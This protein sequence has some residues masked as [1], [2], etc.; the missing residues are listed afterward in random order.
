LTKIDVDTGQTT[1]WHEPGTYPSEPIFVPRPGCQAEDDGV[2]LSVV[3]DSRT[4]RLFLLVLDAS[5][6]TEVART[7]APQRIPL[8]F[9]GQHIAVTGTRHA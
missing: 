8:G 9:H 4:Q 1:N 3:L 2:L 7:Q 5:D 6:L